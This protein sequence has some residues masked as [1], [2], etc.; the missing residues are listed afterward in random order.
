[1]RNYVI[2]SDSGTDL[3]PAMANE[4]DVKILDLMVIME[5]QEPKPDSSVDHK[6]FYAFLRDKKSASTS[7]INPETFS[8]VMESYIKDGFDVLYLGFSSGL[9]NTYNAGRL[10]AEE[11]SEKYP[12]AKIYTCDTLCAS[13]GQG[14]LVYLAAKKRLEGASIE[15]VRDWVE[16]T[17]LHL[18]HQFTVNDLMF[19]KRGGRVSAATAAVGTMLGIKPVMHVDN[20]GHLIKVGTA[21]G[22]KASLDALLDK[23]K[24]TVT[25]KDIMFICHGDC[26]EDAEYVAERA[27]NELGIKEVIIGYTGVVI[28]SHSGPGT[29]AIFYIG[30]ER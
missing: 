15:E 30:T 25:E 29:L 16:A 5:G 20:A 2:L 6:E 10:A 21:R 23:M 3:T 24:A 28:G 9:S 13:L 26:I 12:D 8:E 19:L 18:C 22:R 27:K 1:M 17:K 4:I 11:L 7:A 14:L